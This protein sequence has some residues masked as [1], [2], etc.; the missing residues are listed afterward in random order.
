MEHGI[1]LPQI[2]FTWRI[3]LMSIHT[4]ESSVYDI[5]NLVFNLCGPWCI[6]SMICSIEALL[7]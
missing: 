3:F 4:V 1:Y 6:K 7:S 2:L 5:L